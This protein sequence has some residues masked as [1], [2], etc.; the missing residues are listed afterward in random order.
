MVVYN[1]Y[2][3]LQKAQTLPEERLFI[4]LPV[5]VKINQKVILCC[6]CSMAGAR[7]KAPGVTRDVLI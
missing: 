3:S 7:M 5:T 4:H 6:T 1:K 2:F